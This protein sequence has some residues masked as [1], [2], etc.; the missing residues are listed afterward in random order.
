SWPAATRWSKNIA[1]ASAPCPP[2]PSSMA[3]S[4]R[5]SARKRPSPRSAR[6]STSTSRTSSPPCSRAWACSTCTACPAC[7]RPKSARTATRL[8]S[9]TSM[10]KCSTPS[11]PTKSTWIRSSCTSACQHHSRS[12]GGPMPAVDLFCRV[13]DNFG[14]IG[15]CWRL[16]RQLAASPEVPQVRLWV[17]DLASFQRI[18]HELRPE[19]E[20]QDLQGVRVE[21]WST[22][23]VRYPDPHPLLIEAFACEPPAAVTERLR[24]GQHVWINLE[25]LSA[26]SWVTGCHGLP[27]PQAGGAAKYFFFPGFLPGTGG[28]LREPDLLA[29]RDAFRRDDDA[30]EALLARLGV[31]IEQRRAVLEG[32]M[33]QMFLF[34]YPDAPVPALPDA[35]A[36]QGPETL[37]LVPDSVARRLPPLAAGRLRVQEIPHV[38]QA[39]FDA[40]LWRSDL[41]I[42]RGED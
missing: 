31:A 19:L 32:S 27:S 2:P 17:D 9:P 40:L 6:T 15:V 33:R 30:Y 23:R 3:A 12:R 41:N 10:A 22:T 38:D 20:S 34:C 24:A 8:S 26:E 36:Q 1:W 21:R 42:V 13:V 16:A 29:R 28:L 37:L 11:C 35:L 7:I 39:D 18:Q 25:Y 4:G 14:D 5:C